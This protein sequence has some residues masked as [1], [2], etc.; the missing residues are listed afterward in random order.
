[1]PTARPAA[2]ALVLALLVTSHVATRSVSD[3]RPPTAPAV[4]ATDLVALVADVESGRRH[5][6][7]VGASLP[8]GDVPVTFLARNAAGRPPRIVSDVTGWGER[9]DGTFDVAV[10]RMRRIRGTDWYSLEVRVAP[11]ARIEY[12]IAYAVGE[13]LVDPHNPRRVESPPA[14]EFVTP[15]YEPPPGFV[16]APAAP[17]GTLKHATIASRSAGTRDLVVYTP[18]GLAEAD[19]PLM[20][21]LDRRAEVVSRILD[22]LVAQQAVEPF[23]AAFVG[24]DPPGAGAPSPAALRAFLVAELPAWLSE[25]AGTTTDADRRAILAISFAAKDALD[26]AVLGPSGYGCLGLLVPGRRLTAADIEAVG[27]LPRAP[28]R[29]SILAG[30][31]D[32]ANVDTARLLRR[33]LAA[34]GHAAGYREVPEGHSPRT[35]MHHLA[36][37]LADLFPPRASSVREPAGGAVTRESPDAVFRRQAD[38]LDRRFEAARLRCEDRWRSGGDCL[39]TLRVLRDEEHRLFESV[40]LHRFGDVTESNHWHR[41]RLKFPSRISQLVSRLGVR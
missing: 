38:R 7:I 3:A 27:A 34:A 1:M 22:W 8:G 41:G 35:W 24:L 18:P 25:H 20:V 10:G 11:G 4:A 37:V 30:R 12:Q 32:Q 21:I 36:E 39:A 40:R 17:A 5:T 28:L 9:R 15:G 19:R 2:P 33:S 26:A 14:S 23:V 6:P 16:D 29:V 31:Y 13:N